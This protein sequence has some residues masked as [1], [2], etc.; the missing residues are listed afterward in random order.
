MVNS[1]LADWRLRWLL[2]LLPV[3]L[4][5][6][7]L[8][9]DETR[10]LSI[11]WE[12]RFSQDFLAL[13]FNCAPYSDKGPLLFWLIN[14]SW[15]PFG[16]QVWSVRLGV[17]AASFC[18]LL[19]FERLALRLTPGDAAERNA[20]AKRAAVI[21]GGIVYFALFSSAI[22]FDVVLATFVL[23]A[24]HGI[25]DFDERR[26]P[27]GIALAALGF[28]LGLLTKGPAILL[29]A[30]LVALLGPWWS[31]T[32]REQPGRWYASVLAGVVG[33]VVIAL[34]WA[35]A[36]YGIAGLW[37]EIILHQT[38]GRVVK[39][40]AHQR[41]FWWY[42]MV[43]PFMLLP[44]TL[45]LRAPWRAWREHLLACKAARFGLAWFVPAFAVFCF[46][47]SGKQPHYLLPILPGLALYLAAVLGDNAAQL[48]GRLFGALLLLTGAAF[49][50]VPYIAVHAHE[51]SALDRLHLTDSFLRVV[52]AL[53]P[54]WGALVA[55]LG[56]WL[57]FARAAHASLRALALA[58]VATA[59]CG[60]LALAQDVGPY[61]DVSVAAAR[62]KQIQESGRP[63][64][65]LA[66][67][68]GLFEFPGRFTQPLPKVNYADLRAWCETHP[69]GEIVT[70]YTKY[71]ITAK[72]E[73][74]LPYRFGRIIFWR[75][76]DILS[77]PATSAKPLAPD[78]DETPE[79]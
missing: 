1:L 6:P 23:L 70:F 3:A 55:L 75:A 7:A 73:L 14:L 22:M 36:V 12:M 58:S 5:L 68:H 57:L 51:I 29:D 66:W 2:L 48:R 37:S 13:H 46:A 10:Y 43:L 44:W 42:F 60:M 32:A 76:A 33:G 71:P 8:P 79:D 11:A 25:A 74:E 63:I 52:S 49:A 34:T 56:A 35:V 30:G 53:W 50:A 64:A 61:V 19:L 20:L 9:I 4:F 77:T 41:P 16:P 17:L 26:W 21:L 78:D 15:L 38:V 39:S 67:H 31:A 72:P 65:H 45:S 40:F 54:L 18:S 59:A 28:G 27:R 47:I 24:L 62:I 69:D